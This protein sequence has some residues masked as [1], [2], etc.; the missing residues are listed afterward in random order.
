MS[1]AIASSERCLRERTIRRGWATPGS[2]HDALVGFLKIALP[3]AV[4]A[5]LAYLAVAPL[6][7]RQ[8]FSFI[9]DK[10]KVELAG[11]R[12]RVQAAQYQGQDA[13]GRPFTI[14]AQSAIQATSRRPIVD[15]LGMRAGISLADG[16]A[17]LRADRGRYD[18]ERETVDVVGPILFTAADGYRLESRD[19]AVDLNSR[20]L[21]GENGVAGRMPLGAFRADAMTADL[22]ERTVTLAGRVN[23][24]IVQGRAR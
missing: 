9:L 4:G 18:I 21:R 8:E 17:S 15:I 19:V 11:E 10:N 5:M 7:K 2:G 6:T 12:M 16:P 22:A 24:H 14:A 13:N 3:M 1:E 20:T 23:L